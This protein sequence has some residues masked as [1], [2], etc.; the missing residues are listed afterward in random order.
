MCPGDKF[1]KTQNI[2]DKA[3]QITKW[4][5]Y[6]IEDHMTQAEK[7]ERLRLR[8]DWVDDLLWVRA[9]HPDATNNEKNT[10]FCQK[11]EQREGHS[12]E[13]LDAL[14]NRRPITHKSVRPR[15]NA[16]DLKYYIDNL[17]RCEKKKWSPGFC[18][19]IFI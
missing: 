9:E 16:Y 1:A 4:M 13:A 19:H 11:H 6:P 15:V 8:N 12:K 5:A 18:N 10:L 3:L 2:L 7:N 14:N 17:E